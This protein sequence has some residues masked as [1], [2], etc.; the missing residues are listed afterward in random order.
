MKKII[1]LF[2]AI[3]MVFSTGLSAIV[4]NADTYVYEEIPTYQVDQ[5]SKGTAKLSWY[6]SLNTYGDIDGFEIARYYESSGTY[7]TIGNVKANKDAYGFIQYTYTVS[8]LSATSKYAFAIRTYKDYSGSNMYSNYTKPLYICTSP[9]EP[10]LNSVK[11]ISQ[12]KMEVKWSKVS[13]ATGYEIQYSTNNKFINDGT[14][15]YVKVGSDTASKTI[16]GLAKKKYYV[17][18]RAYIGY[19]GQYFCSDFGR[20][21]SVSITSGATLKQMINAIGTN[22]QGRA[23]IKAYTNNGVDINK[24]S[25][26]Y[27]KLKAIYDWHS[28]HNT[29]NGWNCVGCNSNFNV[30]V[31][32][33]FKD[34][35]I[36]ENFIYLACDNF[37]NN[38]G[39][40]VMHKWSVIYL[41]G[42]PHI[43]DPRIQGYSSNKTG[44]TYFGISPTSTTGK[45]YLFEGYWYYFPT[46]FST[47]SS[48]NSYLSSD[49]APFVDAVNKPKDTSLTVTAKQDGLKL[50]W[51][52]SV[53]AKGYQIQYGTKSDFTDATVI[54]INNRA[55]ISQTI[56]KL[57]S[58]KTYYIRIRP[59][60][61]IGKTKIYGY[62]TST[63]TKKTRHINEANPVSISKLTAKT[64]AFTVEWKAISNATGYQIDYSTSGK[65]GSTPSLTVNG[66]N[67]ISY[68]VSGRK[69]KQKHYV[70]MRT[71]RTVNGKNYYSE[72]SPTKTV[73][74]K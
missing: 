47:G 39:S 40:V 3:I 20:T 48:N 22:N 24:Y 46:Y 42:V 14:T 51:V 68:T 25:T 7:A 67:K 72:W 9:S 13:G 41:A 52:E 64:K 69:A 1:S 10:K 31:A 28:K 49:P 26:T 19:K 17:R 27:D 35:K 57:G 16:S 33:L 30:C 54:D 37:K 66:A 73:T 32:A 2:L 56:S 6:Y 50:S 12:G 36:Y 55:T 59:Y 62:W 44:T 4:A 74:T 29:D 23:V 61:Q 45:K 21:K 5:I 70:R 8:G 38:D 43:F 63:V 71:Y 34:K 11:Y 65:F 58:N 53:N 15:C 18:V 60:K